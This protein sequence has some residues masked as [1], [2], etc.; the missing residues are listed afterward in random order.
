VQL[1][2][3]RRSSTPRARSALTAASTSGGAEGDA[4][5]ALVAVDRPSR[6][7]FDQLQVEAAAGAAQH[8]ALGQD[9]EALV[10]GQ[11]A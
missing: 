2:E 4:L 3:S 6:V 10:V 8:A 5:Q 7:G 1:V 11:H 9:A